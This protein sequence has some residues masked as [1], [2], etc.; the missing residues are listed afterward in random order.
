MLATVQIASQYS[1]VACG[2]YGA[3]SGYV[4][5]SDAPARLPEVM[6]AE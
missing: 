5:I 2:T 4:W 6:S 3:V 1:A